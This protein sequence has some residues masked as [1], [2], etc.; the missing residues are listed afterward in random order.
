M[1][2]LHIQDFYLAFF[3]SPLE[4]SLSC[5]VG[6]EQQDS[7]A[8]I[9]V[10]YAGNLLFFSQLSLLVDKKQS[11]SLTNFFTSFG[12]GESNLNKYV[13]FN[14]FQIEMYLQFRKFKF[15]SLFLS[16]IHTF[17]LWLPRM[18]NSCGCVRIPLLVFV[19]SSLDLCPKTVMTRIFGIVLR[20]IPFPY[21]VDLYGSAVG[22]MASK[23]G[24]RWATAM[25]DGAANW[26]H[27]F[28][29]VFDDAIVQIFNR[30]STPHVST[31][32]SRQKDLGE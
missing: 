11:S 31:S 16:L 27:R 12:W 6:N 19:L 8:S 28:R 23:S 2:L 20:R 26:E 25:W 9:L 13:S 1:T 17:Q 14:I 22:H 30:L 29:S 7:D 32:R 3:A 18:L 10:T 21:W 5:I 4:N 24:S 15:A